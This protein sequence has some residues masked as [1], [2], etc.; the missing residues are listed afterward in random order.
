SSAIATVALHLKSER[1]RTFPIFGKMIL[2]DNLCGNHG[3][4]MMKNCCGLAGSIV[5]L[6]LKLPVGPK[7]PELTLVQALSGAVTSVD[8]STWKGPLAKPL[9]PLNVT[10]L[11]DWTKLFMRGCGWM[12][13][14]S[15]RPI[16]LLAVSFV[17][18]P[19]YP[20]GSV[21]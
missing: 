6:K 19:A 2:P 18:T 4:C 20:A 21:P 10:V 11:P 16:V 12:A 3:T 8:A 7:M 13:L 15:T 17:R 14:V 9:M 5:A 1:R